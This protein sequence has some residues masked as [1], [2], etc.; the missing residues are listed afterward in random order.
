MYLDNMKHYFIG[1]IFTYPKIGQVS[2][3]GS[4]EY[5]DITEPVGRVIRDHL[6]SHFYADDSQSYLYPF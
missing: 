2:I 3:L 4:D 1:N 5:S 6:F